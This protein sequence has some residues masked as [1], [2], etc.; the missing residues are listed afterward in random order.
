MLPLRYFTVAMVFT[1][2]SL[3]AAGYGGAGG[4]NR[5]GQGFQIPADRSEEI[6][7]S[8][9]A[10]RPNRA[11]SRTYKLDCQWDTAEGFALDCRQGKESPLTGAAYV[12]RFSKK[13]RISC[14]PGSGWGAEVLVCKR[15]CNSPAIPRILVESP[16][17]C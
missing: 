9:S 10:Q 13:Y 6:I 16:W 17:E 2:S 3:W 4:E 12:R 1:Y 5:L 14:G 11:Q 15:G 8:T 7:V